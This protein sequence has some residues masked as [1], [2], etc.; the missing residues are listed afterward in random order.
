MKQIKCPFDGTPCQSDC[1]DRFP[2]RL[3]GGCRLTDHLAAGMPVLAINKATAELI[4]FYPDGTHEV[5]DLSDLPAII[6]SVDS[7][8]EL[9]GCRSN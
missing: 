4:G 5:F 2:H 9:S 7:P 8:D 3:E 6:C 1:I